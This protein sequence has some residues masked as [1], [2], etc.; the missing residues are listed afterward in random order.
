MFK[1]MRLQLTIICTLG[2]AAVLIGMVIVAM[3]FSLAQLDK[4]SRESF[5]SNVNSVLFHLN[6][7]PI[8]DQLWLTQTEADNNLWI[9]IE[10]EHYQLQF[11]DLKEERTKLTS[12]AL[13]YAQDKLKFSP[14]TRTHRLL[15]PETLMFD[16]KTGGENYLAGITVMPYGNA[17]LAVTIVKSRTLYESTALQLGM[18]FTL[19]A[20]IA[21]L[22]LGLFAWKF[23]GRVIR[24]VEEN[25]QK[26]NAFVSAASHELRTPLSVITLSAGTI[27][28]SPV[29]AIPLAEKIE[30]E[31]RHMTRLISDLL[32]LASVD[33]KRWKAKFEPAFPKTILLNTFERFELLAEQKKIS[34]SLDLSS[35]DLPMLL[36]DQQKIEQVLSIFLDNAIRYTPSGEAI[37]LS[38]VPGKNSICFSVSDSGPGIPD[39]HKKQIFDRFYRADAARSDKEH[40]GLGLSIASEITLLHKGKLLVIDSSLGGAEFLLHLPKNSGY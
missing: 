10:S 32:F 25:H 31:C 20:L 11:T 2:T 34:L 29:H 4:Q 16:M 39:I 6:S 24:P 33:D 26:Q 12:H 21:I 18:G 3:Q 28:G 1:R 14:F 7:Q 15:E 23:S 8:I 9:R 38:A 22:L 37:V 27:K 40:Y 30:N 5:R 17:A 13:S 19:F 35:S 36:C